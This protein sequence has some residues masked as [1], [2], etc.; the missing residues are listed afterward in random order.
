MDYVMETQR[1]KMLSILCGPCAYLQNIESE[2][3]LSVL[4]G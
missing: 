1:V 4:R 3:S 2:S